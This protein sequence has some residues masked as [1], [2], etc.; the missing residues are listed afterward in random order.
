[1]KFDARGT[2]LSYMPQNTY[3]ENHVSVGSR[4]FGS[5][6]GYGGRF[7]GNKNTKCQN[8]TAIA[9]Q[10]Y[11]FFADL[12]PRPGDGRPTVFFQD[13]ISTLNNSTGFYLD[14]LYSMGINYAGVYGNRPDFYPSAN[15]NF[16]NIRTS[17]P[18]FG[19]CK[20]FVPATSPMKRAGSLRSDGSRNDI[21][22]N[23]LCRYQ[24]GVLTNTKLWSSTGQFTCGAKITGVND[25]AGK[26]CYDVNIRLNVNA[27]GCILPAVPDCRQPTNPRL[28]SP[29]SGITILPAP[30]NP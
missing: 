29:P 19:A 1:M 22:A 20:I 9:G 25:R 11:G 17:S 23:V 10:D 4:R 21:G 3:V 27:N 6:K 18:E 5:I 12:G 28:P 2:G 8:C 15:P 7:R 26:S 14:G 24:N 30:I 16:T 13:T